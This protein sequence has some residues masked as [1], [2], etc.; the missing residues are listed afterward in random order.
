MLGPLPVDPQTS[1]CLTH[2]LDA[3]GAD[4]PA[5]VHTLLDQ[6]IECPE[7]GLEAEIARRT[8][9]QCFEHLGRHVCAEHGREMMGTARSSLESVQSLLVEGMNG[10]ANGL[11]VAGE[12]LRNTRSALSAHGCQQDLTATKHKGIRGAQPGAERLAFLFGKVA[13]KNAWFHVSEYTTSRITSLE[14]ALGLVRHA[15]RHEKS[16][17]WVCF[18]L[19]SKLR[20]LFFI[21]FACSSGKMEGLLFTESRVRFLIKLRFWLLNVY[22][23]SEYSKQ[24]PPPR[25]DATSLTPTHT[26]E[27]GALPIIHQQ[28]SCRGLASGWLPFLILVTSIFITNIASDKSP[29]LAALSSSLS[30]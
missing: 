2:C 25:G 23:S 1:E 21:A 4:H 7:A 9:Q 12:S 18:F 16:S 17:L 13:D 14:Y 3:D 27:P 20:T 28:G 22:M 29:S 10:M 15:L 5:K 11:F 6:E 24:E 8:M 30:S 19:Q 26:S